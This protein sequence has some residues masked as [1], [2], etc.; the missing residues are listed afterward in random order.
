MIDLGNKYGVHI[1]TPTEEAL[2]DC[3][4]KGVPASVAPQF[5]VEDLEVAR[6]YVEMLGQNQRADSLRN[7]DDWEQRINSLSDAIEY[8]EWEL[9]RA[10]VLPMTE[11]EKLQDRL[12][13]LFPQA[14]P[15]D[16][17]QYQGCE[18]VR[19]CE[20]ARFNRNGV[21]KWKEWWE[22]VGVSDCNLMV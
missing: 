7:W 15:G 22:L 3:N 17:V 21:D 1:E 19:R 13:E 8:K 18:H 20:P 5:T 9:K 6:R 16:V 12:N 11:Q 4:M 10:G 2:A 14:H